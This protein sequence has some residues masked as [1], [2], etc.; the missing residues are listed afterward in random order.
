[1]ALK[2]IKSYQ[3][4]GNLQMAT[5]R[6]L[7]SNLLSQPENDD[8]KETFFALNKCASGKLTRQELIEAYWEF[9]YEDM[10]YYEIDNILAM[11][12][13]DKSGSV[14]FNEFLMPAID[15]KMML[16][17]TEKCYKIIVALDT[18]KRGGILLSELEEGLKPKNPV[19]EYIWRKVLNDDDP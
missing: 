7:S 14:K 8:L 17:D 12:D 11:V 19:K 18:K 9:G 3:K 4:K 2:S 15:P 16:C 6:Y 5:L 10:S 13:Q 1:M